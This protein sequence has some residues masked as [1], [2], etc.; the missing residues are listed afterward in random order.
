MEDFSEASMA[1]QMAQ[2][3]RD[4]APFENIDIIVK[5]QK[6]LYEM[7]RDNQG[8]QAEVSILQHENYFLGI[9]LQEVKVSYLSEQESVSGCSYKYLC[10]MK[11]KS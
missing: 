3:R 5:W 2:A 7:N 11:T 1:A 10:R 6:K 4:T 9:G 8:L